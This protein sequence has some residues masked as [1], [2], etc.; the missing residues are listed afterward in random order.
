RGV[1]GIRRDEHVDCAVERLLDRLP[2]LV[3]VARRRGWVITSNKDVDGA[4]RT[5]RLTCER[6]DRIA[7]KAVVA[8]RDARVVAVEIGLW[9]ARRRQVR[10]QRAGA[11]T[12]GWRAGWPDRRRGWR[13]RFGQHRHARQPARDVQEAASTEI[14]HR[15]TI[16]DL[17]ACSAWARS[18]MRWVIGLAHNGSLRASSSDSSRRARV[19]NFGANGSKRT[20]AQ[21]IAS[22]VVVP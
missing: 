19:S 20:L 22:A 16:V 18:R 12:G 7:G 11:A 4:A 13:A 5:R 8:I 9:A 10:R 3:L 17:T 21:K 15:Q 6:L 1:V 2:G 14:A